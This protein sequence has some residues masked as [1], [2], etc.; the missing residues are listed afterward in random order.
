MQ[1]LVIV[2]IFD[3]V[4]PGAFRASMDWSKPSSSATADDMAT[5]YSS[6]LYSRKVEIT[7]FGLC[8]QALGGCELEESDRSCVA[9][10]A[11]QICSGSE[12]RRLWYLCIHGTR[13]KMWWKSEN[14]CKFDDT[15]QP[16]EWDVPMLYSDPSRCCRNPEN[17]STLPT[18]LLDRCS[19][20]FQVVIGQSMIMWTMVQWRKL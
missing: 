11:V 16:I 15:S 4:T 2:M 20:I 5:L 18:R 3:P 13:L 19:Q 9:G 6:E 12:V 1:R 8:D 10:Q 7:T 17:S 14:E